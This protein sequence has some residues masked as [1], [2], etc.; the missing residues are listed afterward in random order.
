MPDIGEVPFN[1]ADEGPLLPEDV[2]VVIKDD[3]S[4]KVGV[5]DF[6]HALM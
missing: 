1:D 2:G 3:N 5:L 6:V 4:L